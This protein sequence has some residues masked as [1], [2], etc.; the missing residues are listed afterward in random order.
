MAA[1]FAL[2]KTFNLVGKC[3]NRVNQIQGALHSCQRTCVSMVKHSSVTDVCNL[4]CILQVPACACMCAFHG[5]KTDPL[6]S[7]R[8]GR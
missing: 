8:P 2:V 7:S 3:K 4:V 6:S 1:S 5:V